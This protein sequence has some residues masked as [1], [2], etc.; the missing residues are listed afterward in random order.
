MCGGLSHT[1]AADER[2]DHAAADQNCRDDRIDF[3]SLG[4][5]D[6]DRNRARLDSMFLADRDRYEQ[7]HDAEEDENYAENEK[8][9]HGSV[10]SVSSVVKAF[11]TES[12]EITEITETSE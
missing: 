3:L 10:I 5:F 8:C 9:T 12:T 1:F 7:R 2:E 6:S 11:T 4:R